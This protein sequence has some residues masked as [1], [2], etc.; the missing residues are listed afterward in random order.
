VD[1]YAIARYRDVIFHIAQDTIDITVNEVPLTAYDLVYIRDFHG[2]EPERN[3]IADYCQHVGLPFV[4]A[5][6]AISQ[7]ISKL[8]QYMTFA[9][10]G[11]S[12]PR[13]VYAHMYRLQEAAERVLSYPMIVKSI[14]AKSGNDNFYVTSSEEFKEI[15]EA[16]ADGKFVAQEAIPNDGDYRVIILGDTASCVYRRVAQAG[17]HRNNVSQGGDKQ[18]LPVDA[19]PKEAIELAVRASQV[20]GRDICGADIMLHQQTGTPVVLEANFNFGIR[21]LPGIVSEELHGL[22]RYLHHR[23]NS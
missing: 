23:A 1:E 21:A 6:T 17:D 4:N 11:L 20:L 10:H 2:Y 16:H 9:F 22:A 15:V 19:I 3:T 18:Y 8:A 13:S 5:D 14:V 12:F 7:K